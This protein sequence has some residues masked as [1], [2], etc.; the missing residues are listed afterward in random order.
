[1][2]L[3]LL[4]GKLEIKYS[5]DNDLEN[6]NDDAT[7]EDYS[8]VLRYMDIPYEVRMKY[9]IQ[10]YRKDKEKWGRLYEHAKQL[11]S[12]VERLKNVLTV[13][14]I[15]ES[16]ME[17]ETSQSKM[18]KNQKAEIAELKM[19][20]KEN[21]RDEKIQAMKRLIE[22][23][24]PLRKHKYGSYRRI[25]RDHNAYIEELQKLLAENRIAYWPRVPTTE[26]EREGIE[27]IDENA[28]RT[29]DDLRSLNL[30]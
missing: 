25:I 11:E 28:V 8:R 10:A 15:D 3:K 4:G 2:K 13:N 30:E 9:L 14:G 20:L 27:N 18:F 1:M 6:L 24:Y 19:K 5:S 12:E 16:G 29:I 21:L 22:V 7:P 17:N 26:L 23:E